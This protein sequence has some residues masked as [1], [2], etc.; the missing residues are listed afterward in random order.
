[1]CAFSRRLSPGTCRLEGAVAFRRARRRGRNRGVRAAHEVCGRG[2]QRI[3]RCASWDVEV[4]QAVK[5]HRPLSACVVRRSRGGAAAPLPHR[6]ADRDPANPPA[7]I[8]VP[9]DPFPVHQG[10]N[11]GLLRELSGDLAIPDDQKGGACDRAEACL[12]EFLELDVVAISHH[13]LH[14]V[15]GRSRPQGLRR[16]PP[17]RWGRRGRS[18]V[19]QI[20]GRRSHG[21]GCRSFRWQGR[22]GWCPVLPH[23]GWSRP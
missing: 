17:M 1:M 2:R 23:G 20:R 5:P 6:E 8:V 11:E 13:A 18:R 19:R 3:T 12:K 16:R 9:T 21:R 15:T 22:R 4:L 14:P 10:L 7:R